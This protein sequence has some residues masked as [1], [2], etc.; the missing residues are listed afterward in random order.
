VAGQPKVKGY[1]QSRLPICLAM[2]EKG[3]A[4]AA[5]TGVKPAT[6]YRKLEKE[7]GRDREHLKKWHQ[8]YLKYPSS[9]SNIPRALVL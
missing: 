4:V 8:L 9:T 5:Y 7:T 6:S 1:Y 3:E 2:W